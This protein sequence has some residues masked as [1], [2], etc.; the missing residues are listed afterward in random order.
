MKRILSG[1]LAFSMLALLSTGI[2]P[3]NVGWAEAIAAQNAAYVPLYEV[4]EGAK[5]DKIVVISDLHLGVD[6][7]YAETVKNRQILVDFLHHVAA[8]GD[9]AELVIAGDFFDEWFQPFSAEPHTDSSAFYHKAAENNKDVVDAIKELMTTYGKKVTY[10]PGNHDMTLDFDTIADIIPGINQARDVAGLGTYRTGLRNE[11]VIEHGHRYNI[12][13]APDNITNSGLTN[14]KSILPPGYFFTRIGAS[15]VQ[16][17]MPKVEKTYPPVTDPGKDDVSQYGAYLY[18]Q[19]WMWTLETLPVKEGLDDKVMDAGFSGFD[20]VYSISDVLPAQGADGKINAKVF[21]NIQDNWDEVQKRNGVPTYIA[22]NDAVMQSASTTVVDAQAVTQHFNVDPTIEVVVFGHTH[23]PIYR[24]ITSNKVYA[25]S[26]TWIDNNTQGDGTTF[27]LI[28]L[29]EDADTV[30]LY[31]YNEDGSIKSLSGECPKPGSVAAQT[32]NLT[33]VENARDLGGYV[34]EDGRKVKPGVLLRT[35]ML[36]GATETDIQTLTNTYHLKQVIDL[37]TTSEVSESP[38]PKID[39]VTDTHLKILDESATADDKSAVM[40]T[41]FSKSS[42]SVQELV[43]LIQNGTIMDDMYTGVL[44]SQ[45]MQ[46]KFHEFFE[47]LL[48]NPDGAVLFHCK[49]GK[50]RTGEAAVLLLTALGVNRETCMQDFALT[51]DFKK[52][53]IDSVVAQAK[54]ITED[55]SVLNTV[56]GLVGVNP[57]YMEKVFDESEAQYGS[58]MGFIKQ[59]I[60]LTDDE[61]QQLR[62]MYLE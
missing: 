58:M 62:D 9:I 30:G 11:I 33:G 16:E 24:E 47:R 5:A 38:D 59:G 10:L 46:Q 31:K 41:K 35:A 42:R 40:E 39:G 53:T 28:G 7:A 13:C 2:L 27:V 17:G 15:S 48:A 57:S 21:P 43:D 4:A 45:Y 8:T 1:I 32:L 52:T 49:S 60:G 61:V 20:D 25:N 29:G 44:T 14:G 36:A 37:R 56:A 34:T 51:N 22:F 12:F 55:E 26:G 54:K 50:D 23:V 3:S 6:D 18:H 19:M